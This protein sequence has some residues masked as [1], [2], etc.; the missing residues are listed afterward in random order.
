M[1]VFNT[2]GNL[3]GKSTGLLQTTL[4][5]LVLVSGGTRTS[6]PT[7]FVHTFTSSGTLSVDGTVSNVEVILVGGGGSGNASSSYTDPKPGLT[8][9]F[10]GPGGQGGRVVV[11]TN[12][13]I[14]SPV[15]VVV[16]SAPLNNSTFGPLSSAP[17]SLTSGGT[18]AA[19]PG[20]GAT[21]GTNGTPTPQGTFGGGGGGGGYNPGKP[22]APGGAG[23]GGSGGSTPASSATPGSANT[24]GGGGGAHYGPGTRG[25][26]PGGPGVVIVVVPRDQVKE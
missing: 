20:G 15:P 19:Q 26:A 3:S 25:G 16:G 21:A 18:R 8:T 2:L 22:G 10:G 6:T 4:T 1:P 17:G 23:G 24:G 11:S 12:Q 9:Y 5:D 14:S 13:T 7:S